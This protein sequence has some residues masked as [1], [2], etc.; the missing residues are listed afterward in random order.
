MAVGHAQEHDAHR[1]GCLKIRR[2][3]VGLHHK[4]FQHPE[5]LKC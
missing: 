2:K 3:R 5:H 1:I 4:P